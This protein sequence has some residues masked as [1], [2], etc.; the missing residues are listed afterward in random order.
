[1]ESASGKT[2]CIIFLR[3]QSVKLVSID[4]TVFGGLVNN[5]KLAFASEPRW[6]RSTP[7]SV[8]AP[9]GAPMV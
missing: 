4:L 8:E 3:R 9:D 7:V 5:G 6:H 1:M 2:S